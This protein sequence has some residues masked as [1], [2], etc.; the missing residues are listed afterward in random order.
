VGAAPSSDR[1]LAQG[2]P[3]RYR[4]PWLA[5]FDALLDPDLV[6]GVTILD[7]GSGRRPAIGVDD[8]PPGCR[9]VGLD[10][11]REELEAAPPGAYEE[12]VVGDV[13][14]R[15]PELEGRFDLI[16]SWQALE[17]VKPLAPAFENMR[18]YLRP[19]GH[20]VAQL[21]GR[22]AVFALVGRVVPHRAGT[23]L[24][25]RLL[26][27]EPETVFPAWYDGCYYPALAQMLEPWSA[28]EIVP[29]YKG[30]DYMR[31]SRVLHRL[32]LAYENWAERGG[33]RNLA[34]HYLISAWR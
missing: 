22:F 19:G 15:L 1:T 4:E 11:S 13:T 30:G 26:G 32:Y 28:S 21:S 8:R 24:L 9:Y 16:V 23:W 29:R 31:F 7:V 17:H 27:R 5:P 10:V 34:T 25:Q 2:A 3:E 33:H 14:R 20:L 6:S 18:L 12:L